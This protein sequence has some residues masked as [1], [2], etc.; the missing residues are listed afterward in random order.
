MPKFRYPGVA[1]AELERYLES[2]ENAD[3]LYLNREQY[4]GLAVSSRSWIAS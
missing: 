3:Y 2:S 4:R 1:R